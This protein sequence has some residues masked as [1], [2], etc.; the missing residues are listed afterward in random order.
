MWRTIR[1]I[2]GRAKC[3]AENEAIT[4]N[5]SSFPLS[6][7]LAKLNLQFNTSKMVKHTCSGE[8]RVV[9]R[10]TKRKPLK[11][12]RTLTADLVMNTI[13]SCSTTYLRTGL[14][15]EPPGHGCHGLNGRAQDK[16]DAMIEII[17]I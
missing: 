2:D 8:A 11:R 7:Q 3:E 14:F 10:K 6:K 12:A 4:F 16:V 17:I 15:A 13:K 5:G 1:G 9:M